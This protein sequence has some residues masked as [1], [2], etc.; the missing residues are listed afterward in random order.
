M[1]LITKFN[2]TFSIN[3][4][5]HSSYRTSGHL[6]ISP[7]QIELLPIWVYIF[8]YKIYNKI[9]SNSIK[10]GDGGTKRKTWNMKE[11]NNVYFVFELIMKGQWFFNYVVIAK[12]K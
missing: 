7:I 9:L 10:F 8:N 4:V 2:K 12:C 3:G 1:K 5:S 11:S 6:C